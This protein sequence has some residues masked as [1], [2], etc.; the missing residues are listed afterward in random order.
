MFSR[1][2]FLQKS[3]C[4]RCR[5]Y[6]RPVVGRP[7]AF[8]ALPDN[9][10]PCVTI[11]EVRNT[12]KR[13][14]TRPSYQHKTD[15]AGLGR[16]KRLPRVGRWANAGTFFFMR[17][18]SALVMLVLSSVRIRKHFAKTSRKLC[19]SEFQPST[20]QKNT[21][22]VSAFAANSACVWRGGTRSRIIFKRF[23]ADCSL[24][25]SDDNMC[26]F[27]PWSLFVLENAIQSY[28]HS[29][30]NKGARA[31]NKRRQF[32]TSHDGCGVFL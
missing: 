13:T 2:S 9:K 23:S 5:K 18:S 3:P 14:L 8:V 26:L 20:T 17:P 7:F 11:C 10:K 27:W 19:A 16:E 32:K 21:S 12:I 15:T 28:V 24:I 30:L 31:K 22:K 4:G 1:G 29:S 25:L 6:S